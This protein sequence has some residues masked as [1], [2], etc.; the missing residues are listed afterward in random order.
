M[1]TE[2]VVEMVV[3]MTCHRQ[4]NAIKTNEPAMGAHPSSYSPATVS[5]EES[6]GE[7]T[8]Y[9]ALHEPTC[10]RIGWSRGQS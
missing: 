3:C 10:W 9:V 5:A 4:P 2:R 1:A 6:N 7:V 8:W